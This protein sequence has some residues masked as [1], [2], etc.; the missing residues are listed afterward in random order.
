M[1][2]SPTTFAATRAGVILGTAAYM[3]PEQAKGKPLDRRADIW[4]FGC[5]LFEML[6]GQQAF[7]G[8]TV[9]DV[10][11][12]VIMKDPDWAVLPASTPESIRKLLRRCLEKDPKRRLRDI[13]EARIAVDETLN[14]KDSVAPMS[15]PAGSAMGTSPLS[16]SPVGIP[17]LQQPMW[18]RALPWA[19]AA[20]LLITTVFLAVLLFREPSVPVRP[21]R[22]YI[23]PPEKT[24]FA[25]EA[26]VGT[27][28]VSPDGERLV[29]AARN[30]SGVEMLWVR[31]LESLTAQPL[32]GT[33]GASFP[34]WSPDSHFVAYFASGKLLKIDT[35]GGPTQTICDAPN[36]RGGTWSE[37]GTIVFAPLTSGGLEQVSAAGGTPTP[38]GLID[39]SSPL[40]FRWPV[41]LPDGRHFIFWAGNPFAEVSQSAN[42]I[43]LG[44]LDGKDPKFL[45][46]AESDALYAPPGY[47][48][49]L[50]GA[51]LVA[52]PF[53]ARRLELT[54]EAFPLAEHVSNPL[55]YRLG[56]FSASQY[57][58]LVYHS[59]SAAPGQ[60][61]W[62]DA[63]GK[64]LGTVGEPG[65]IWE[66]RLSPDGKTLVE[67]V[68]DLHSK[69]NDLWVVDLVRGV[70][71]RFTFNPALHAFPAWSPD[72]AKIAFSSTRSGDF[73]IYLES[74][75]GTGT[76][77]PLV[78]DNGVKRVR[79]WSR[80]GR[81]IA[82]DRLSLHG[83]T[84][85]AI[86]ILPLFGDKKP[87]PFLQSQFN[88]QVP[89]FSPDGKW[90]AYD[91]NESGRV[92][93]YVVPFPQGNG[94]WQVSTSGGSDPL[95][96][97][98][99]KEL[100][101]LSPENRLTAV[102]IQ[103]KSG[104]LEIGN[105]QALFQVNPPATVGV[106]PYD[107]AP[108]GKK[109]VVLTQPPQSSAEPITLVTNWMA[110]LKKK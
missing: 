37:S 18:R 60:V 74:A 38:L 1:A 51:T 24:S 42:G 41:F 13:G 106:V 2:N 71:T 70:R 29:F 45:V 98:D 85:W 65:L 47:L 14:G 89:S 78:E 90:L 88:E 7:E 21:A 44:S 87:F 64:Q 5:V 28:V 79:D 66:V 10:L 49:F 84:G 97:Q 54:G 96:R 63:S 31:P 68:G 35:F 48:L 22:A 75:N 62:M 25:F 92:E 8:E 32:V 33:E 100:F 9:S 15:S 73:N 19:A 20:I 61:V 11:A 53:D 40:T 43:Y 69:N 30:S 107:V 103:E 27:P 95:W 82:Y 83:E 67:T 23:L 80:D 16:G 77:E 12:A 34:F 46:P 4:A 93:V 86:W 108:D 39:K 3:A 101:Y 99:G 110:L 81:Y 55:N 72:G 52:Q 59:G 57:G 94:K 91:S 17:A 109:F 56:Q 105:P 76:A 104:S 102:A 36:G 58:D 6:T 50:K 26:E